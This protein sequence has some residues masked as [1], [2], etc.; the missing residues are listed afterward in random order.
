MPE[1]QSLL[2]TYAFGLFMQNGVGR[3]WCVLSLEKVAVGDNYFCDGL[4]FYNDDRQ[5]CYK[6]Q[7]G[8]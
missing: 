3:F 5:S 8:V 7:L 1:I 4:V 6:F 2:T